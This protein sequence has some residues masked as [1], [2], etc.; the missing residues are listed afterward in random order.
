MKKI[1]LMA[2]MGILLVRANAQLQIDANGFVGVGTTTTLARFNIQPQLSVP[3]STNLLIGHWNTSNEGCI[4]IG[5]HNQYSWIQSWNSLPLYINQ[6]GNNVIFCNGQQ[7]GDIGIGYGMTTP[8]AKLHVLGAILA[9]GTIT[10]SDGRLKKNIS[11]IGSMNLICKDLKPVSYNFDIQNMGVKME[12]ID[13]SKV[14]KI[15]KEFYKRTH[16]GFIA[17]DVKE[18]F[19]ELVY[20]DINGGLSIDYQSFIP[21]L[22]KL[23]QE[24][25]AKIE[26]LTSEIELI[27]K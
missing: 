22:F 21:I 17:Q 16:Y 23:V 25:G 15:D 27:K 18:I 1:I 3:G 7:W 5:V 12:G 6:Q 26:Q 11:E 2:I 4:S 8:S 19:P 20:E 9:T 13:T 14:S 24:Q 10:S